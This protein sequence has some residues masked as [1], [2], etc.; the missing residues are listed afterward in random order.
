VG[1]GAG[2]DMVVKQFLYISPNIIR[3]INSRRMRW[4]G[5]IGRMGGMRIEY[6]TLIGNMKGRDH[7]QDLGVSGI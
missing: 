3:V 4:T 5:P 1:P 6:K 2:L 7:S